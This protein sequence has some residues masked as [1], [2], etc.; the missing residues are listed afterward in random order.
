[1]V[2]KDDTVMAK[3][4]A[5]MGPD[6]TVSHTQDVEQALADPAAPGVDAVVLGR[7]LNDDA[8]EALRR[9]F[10]REGAGPAIVNS[11][12]PH[13]VL[14]AAQVRGA[15]SEQRGEPTAVAGLTSRELR[16]HVP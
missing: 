9:R 7:A 5:D 13:G 6:F 4:A 10:A 2:G 8:R 16:L 14:V 1:M 11:L 12:G 15:L 3:M